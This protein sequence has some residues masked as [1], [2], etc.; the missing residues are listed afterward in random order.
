MSKVL[1][2][3]LR[4][5][6]FAETEEILKKVRRPRNTYFNEAIAFYN[7]LWNRRQ[8]ARQLAKE[9]QAVAAESLTVLAEFEAFASR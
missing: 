7:K 2:L 4:E 6:I 9:S 8:L 5:D 3:K 1:S